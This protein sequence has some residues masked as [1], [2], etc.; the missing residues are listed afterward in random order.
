MKILCGIPTHKANEECFLAALSSFNHAREYMKK[1]TEVEINLLVFDFSDPQIDLMT[2][3]SWATRLCLPNYGFCDNFNIGRNVTLVDGCD[4]FFFFN[5]DIILHEK[6]LDNTI[7]YLEN[8]PDV[9]FLGG[10]SQQGGWKEPFN[11]QAIPEPIFDFEDIV[12]LSRLNWEF[13]AGCF[14]KEALREV[15]EM[16]PMFS[17]R[18]GLI[19]DNDYLYRLRRLG[20][21]TVRSSWSTFFHGKACTQSKFRDPLDPHDP[22]RLRG[23]QWMNLKWGVDIRMGGVAALAFTEPF[24]GKEMKIIDENTVELDGEKICLLKV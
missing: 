15:G 2:L 13:S 20:W 6:F 24:N 4:Y 3:P 11:P 22:H 16:D 5:D 1:Y 18:L 14:R 8:N 23:I 17:P 21:R 9:G 10:S 12:S 19:S 7:F